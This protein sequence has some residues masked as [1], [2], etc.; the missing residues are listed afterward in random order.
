[1]LRPIKVTG[2]GN[3]H[4]PTVTF[5]KVYYDKCQMSKG[6][7]SQF[8]PRKCDDDEHLRLYRLRSAVLSSL[9]NATLKCYHCDKELQ[10]A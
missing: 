6:C 1:M 10:S 3:G 4:E 9:L 5:I 2:Y 7:S 8:P